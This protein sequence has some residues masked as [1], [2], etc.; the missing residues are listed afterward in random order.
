MTRDLRGAN[1]VRAESILLS[2]EECAANEN[3]PSE[4][5]IAFK[6]CKVAPPM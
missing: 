4:G 5:N 6:A 1:N 3:P 2:I